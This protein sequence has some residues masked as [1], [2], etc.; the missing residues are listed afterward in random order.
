MRQILARLVGTIRGTAGEREIARELDAHLA[1]IEDDLVARGCDRAEAHRRARI[2]LGGIERTKEMQRDARTLRWVDD[3]RQDLRHAARQL[4]GSPVFAVTAALSLAVALGANTAIFTVANGLLLRPPAGIADPGALVDIGNARPDGG[5]NPTSFANYVDVR[6]RVTALSSVYGSGMFPHPM[7]LELPARAPERA[8]VQQVTTNYFTTLGVVPAA[9]RLF[10]PADGDHLTPSAVAVISHRLWVGRF[11]RE[12]S[13]IGQ[14]IRLNGRVYTLAGVTPPRFQGTGVFATDV[15]VPLQLSVD[16]RTADSILTNRRGAWLM[17]GARVAP[18]ATL[19][20]AADE[21]AALGRSLKREHGD[22]MAGEGLHL[23]PSSSVPGNRGVIVALMVV[24]GVIVSLVLTVASANVAGLLLARAAARQREFALRLA[25]GA[26]RSR[27]VRQLIAETLLLFAIGAVAGL[28]LAPLLL[29]AA[30]QLPS[31]PFPIDVPLAFDWRV[32]FFTAALTFTA[33]MLSGLAPARRAGRA[34]VMTTI[35]D[36]SHGSSRRSHMRSAFVVVQIAASLVLGIVGGLFVHTLYRAGS[37]NTGYDPRG[38]EVATLDV[39][40]AGYTTETGPRFWRALIEHASRLPEVES[41]TAAQVI[42][43]GFESM[44]FGW[45]TAA[46]AESPTD[47]GMSLSWNVVEPGFFRTLRIPLVA[48][49]DFTA[50]DTAGAEP[51]VILGETVARRLFGHQS[52]LGQTVAYRSGDAAPQ[53]LQVVGIA[54]DIASTNLVDGIDGAFVYLPLQQRYAQTLSSRLMLVVRSRDGQRLPGVLRALVTSIEPRLP[55][56][57]S[58]SLE[59]AA[60]L[61]LVPQRVM[62]TLAGGLG[63]AG[64]ILAAVGIYGVTA[65]LVARRTREIGLRIALGATPAVVVRMI[66][67]RG[68]A[69]VAVG[70]TIGFALAAVVT[71]VLGVFLFGLPP[72]DPI[73]FAGTGGVFAVVTLLA[74]YIPAKQAARLDPLAALRRE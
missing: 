2:A 23:V 7:S 26:G 43:G 69:I 50:A 48:G 10:A 11:N 13:A 33:A 70:L 8:F 21:V 61:G 35:K 25:L 34:D 66:L 57:S 71:Q 47:D 31:L 68:V 58:S 38:V 9:G 30:R 20:Q 64:L 44:R 17:V 74:C 46:S 14:P 73:A 42:P 51:V 41:A 65:Y 1:L 62:A 49:R 56:I 53:Q 29:E 5:L 37:M 40:M 12:S 24:L 45:L 52:A 27:I 55:L 3:A 32:L 22:R 67:G 28:A 39:G 19:A 4:R 54:G 16:S 63:V 18:G 36:D 72:L 6:D 59:E 15:W 60:R